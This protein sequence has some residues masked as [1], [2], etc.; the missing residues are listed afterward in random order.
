MKDA[1][2]KALLADTRWLRRL[3]RHL[4]GSE[5][6]ADDIC[7]ETLAAAMLSPAGNGRPW[8]FRVARNL[9][10]SLLRREQRRGELERVVAREQVAPSA[11]DLAAEAELQ[12]A[13]VNAL[14]EL[15]EPY[16]ETLLLRYMKGLSVAAV[17]RR[18]GVPVETVRTRQKRALARLRARLDQRPGGRLALVLPLAV[19]G[20]PRPTT[21]TLWRI[22]LTKTKVGVA[23]AALAL[24]AAVFGW[25]AL[26]SGS[27]VEEGEDQTAMTIGPTPDRP[28]IPPTRMT[29]VP[30]RREEVVAG[31]GASEPKALVPAQRPGHL[32]V[33]VRLNKDDTTPVEGAVVLLHEPRRAVPRA[34]VTAADGT[35][36]FLDV[37]PGTVQIEVDRSYSP[38]WA[39]IRPGEEETCNVWVW[40]W[41]V[42]GRVRDVHGRPVA[43]AT[44]LIARLDRRRPIPVAT[45]D[46][47][48]RFAVSTLPHA[49]L[50]GATSPVHGTS[51]FALVKRL[52]QQEWLTAGDEKTV[53]VN[54]VLPGG[55]AAVRGIVRD[56]TGRPV[57]DAWVRVG[58]QDGAVKK[59]NPSWWLPP[60][61]QVSTDERGRFE[62]TGLRPGK[63]PIHVYAKGHAFWHGEVECPAFAT[64]DQDVRLHRGG[65]LIGKVTDVRGDAAPDA[66]VR[67]PMV[68]HPLLASAK[69]DSDGSFRLDDLP[70]G[71][72]GV[73]VEGGNRGR[74]K[75][76]IRILAG[77]AVHHDFQLG[78][79]PAIRGVLHDA[80]G[81]P[82]VG[83]R[84]RHFQDYNEEVKTDDRGAFVI[85]D[86]PQGKHEIEIIEPESSC[87]IVTLHEVRPSAEAEAKVNVYRI[88][89]ADMPTSR[90]R[91]RF[92]GPER[93]EAEGAHVLV[94]QDR[95]VAAVVVAA[96]KEGGF[97]TPKL[98]PGTYEVTFLREGFEQ[99]KLEKVT[100]A[101]N[102]DRDLGLIRLEPSDRR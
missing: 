91:G 70:P 95:I 18:M 63:L 31:G 58:L 48:G 59:G 46:A 30:S 72:L 84:V 43:H 10:I 36:R 33:R 38:R 64:V 77:E 55:P 5:D 4:V 74:T 62:A 90:I 53:S 60:P 37:A 17:A 41:N 67:I 25:A 96:D 98:P 22:V 47:N 73:E 14:M 6:L 88:D 87:L 23:A 68:T 32:L 56:P 26:A 78:G 44:V 2:A 82:L 8:L 93:A 94:S 51:D 34:Q 61:F 57:P 76:P 1:T 35:A 13:A 100:V 45:T 89:E 86:C 69:T 75:E 79:G 40:G 39:Q 52:Q 49:Y 42:M 11:G 15:E 50:V 54:L 9:A 101:R 83:W 85:R 99:R 29:G 20:W 16:R 81:K 27:S 21:A 66:E 24:L 97:E 92:A 12:R 80:S 19:P 3:A 7:Q 28:G 71:E 65:S 102:R